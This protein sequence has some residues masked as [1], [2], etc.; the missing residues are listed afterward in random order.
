LLVMLV[1]F[2]IANP[3]YRPVA[4]NSRRCSSRTTSGTRAQSHFR[5]VLIRVPKYQHDSILVRSPDDCCIGDHN[6]GP[7]SPT[8][9]RTG[10]GRPTSGLRRG[11]ADRH[12]SRTSRRASDAIARPHCPTSSLAICTTRAKQNGICAEHWERWTETGPRSHHDRAA[13]TRIRTEALS[14]C[15]GG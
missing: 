13:T 9:P 12:T 5:A 7:S 6:A 10:L 15:H 11:I 8:A 14:V 4:R 1:V 2:A 3:L